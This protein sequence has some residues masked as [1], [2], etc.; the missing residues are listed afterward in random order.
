MILF[1]FTLVNGK[2]SFDKY[3]SHCINA[4]GMEEKLD[5]AFNCTKIGQDFEVDLTT[6]LFPNLHASALEMVLQLKGTV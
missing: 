2:I 3:V 1:Y 5:L 6:A 4:E